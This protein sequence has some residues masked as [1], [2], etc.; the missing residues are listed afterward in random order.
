M[1]LGSSGAFVL[2]FSMWVRMSEK[3][4]ICVSSL[5]LKRAI[6]TKGSSM[7]S[8]ST[9][10]VKVKSDCQNPT[11]SETLP[12]LKNDFLGSGLRRYLRFHLKS[13]YLD[14]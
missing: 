7:V 1:S 3:L 11:S 13:V 12:T 2:R 9:A 6:E 14:R 8:D 5:S 4:K 10:G